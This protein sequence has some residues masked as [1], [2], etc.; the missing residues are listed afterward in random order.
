MLKIVITSLI[1]ITISACGLHP[2]IKENCVVDTKLVEKLWVL[3]RGKT[4]GDYINNTKLY[5]QMIKLDNA[6]KNKLKEE[7]KQCSIK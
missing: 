3:D 7:L 6:R 1:L 2:T 4:Y 5:E